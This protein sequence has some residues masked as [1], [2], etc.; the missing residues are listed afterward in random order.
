[1][2]SQDTSTRL[3]LV[4]R[5]WRYVDKSGDCWEWTGATNGRYGH[6]SRGPG[7][8]VAAAHRVSWEIH[9]GPIPA[10]LFVL[11]RCDNPPCVRPDHLF[12]GTD[13]DNSDDK[14]RKGRARTPSP[15]RLSMRRQISPPLPVRITA[16]VVI[17]DA[18]MKLTTEQINEIRALGTSGLLQ[19]EIAAHYGVNRVTISRIIRGQR[20]ADG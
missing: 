12:L 3:P 9:N 7:L 4:G 13:Q 10:G 15:R 1:M 14:L 19:R 2:P 5:F 17:S 8:G 6:I 20:R 16:D 18:R 11:H